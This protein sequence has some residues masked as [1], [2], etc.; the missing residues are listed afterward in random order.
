MKKENQTR[1]KTGVSNLDILLHGGFPLRAATVIGGTPGSGK[2]T[3]IQQICFH[4]ASP[5]NKVLY[6][7]TLSEPTIKTLGYLKQLAFFNP[8]KM[9]D[10]SVQFYDLGALLRTKGLEEAATLLMEEIKKV[11]PAIVVIDSFKVF[12]DL[13]HSQEEYRK[14][15]YQI[16]IDL[17]AWECT[18]FLLG[19]F[20]FNELATNPL[21]S[22]V[23]GIIMM[24]AV[25]SSGEEQRFIHIKKMRGTDH[26]RNRHPFM[27]SGAGITPYAPDVTLRRKAASDSKPGKM[28][29][30]KTGVPTL[31]KLLGTG[32]PYGSS[33]LISGVSGTGKSLL[34]LEMIYRGAKEFREKGIFFS[35]EET[36]ERTLAAAETLGW[37]L[38]REMKK[39]TVEIVCVPQPD[40]LIEQNLLM[41]QE[42]IERMKA[43][44]VAI[45]S[46]SVFLHKVKEPEIVCA[47]LY[48]IVTVIQNAHALGFLTADLPYDGN[49]IGSL[50]VE[51]TTMD[52]II[53]LTSD[54]DGMERER[55]LEIY[56][57]RGT[58]H[59]TGRHQMTIGTEG[60]KITPR[61]LTGRK[62]R[63]KARVRK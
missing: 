4:N 41:M 8:E 1:L 21:S 19:E 27:I 36:R 60:I 3:M 17:M 63:K 7:Q 29:R 16:A 59:V 2:S 38:E 31:D 51:A 18:S 52:G 34:S 23:D 57:L 43:R 9:A 45:D 22:I 49:K 44:R 33:I 58:R 61:P 10:G 46:V 24:E 56:K 47:K 30:A 42:R 15:T 12:E 20:S 13:A 35:F 55:Y 54:L 32:I 14:F 39:G 28:E 37:D 40:I 5:E 50:G 26:D 62:K 48:Q 11:G 25:E 53:L 6:F